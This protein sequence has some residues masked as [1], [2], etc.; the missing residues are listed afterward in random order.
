MVFAIYFTL[1]GGGIVLLN[2]LIIQSLLDDAALV[3]RVAEVPVHLHLV[4]LKFA[5]FLGFEV[6]DSQFLECEVFILLL[7]SCLITVA[8][9]LVEVCLPPLFVLV[10][11]H[12]F[13]L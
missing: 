5:L 1:F 4:L 3:H 7:L 6:V 10:D 8:H 12:L 11:L 2:K 9:L 13:T